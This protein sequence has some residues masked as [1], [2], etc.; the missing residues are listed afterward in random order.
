MWHVE[1]MVQT[2]LTDA[3]SLWWP[4]PK[5]DDSFSHTTSSSY[6]LLNI[7]MLSPP[8]SRYLVYAYTSPWLVSWKWRGNRTV[9]WGRDRSSEWERENE[10]V[11]NSAASKEQKWRGIRRVRKGEIERGE[12]R[13]PSVCACYMSGIIR[14][15]GQSFLV[16]DLYIGWSLSSPRKASTTIT[17]TSVQRIR[18]GVWSILVVRRS[19]RREV[20]AAVPAFG[21]GGHPEE[22]EE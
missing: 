15:Q 8:L 20:A 1:R 18:S 11:P 6:P 22:E 21:K 9:V 13:F 7:H 3:H 12:S 19:A 2:S 17:A 5:T 4:T 10:C 16:L 14:S